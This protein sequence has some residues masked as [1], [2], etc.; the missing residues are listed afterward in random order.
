[1]LPSKLIMAAA[2]FFVG[3]STKVLTTDMDIQILDDELGTDLAARR[4]RQTAKGR[5]CLRCIT[6]VTIVVVHHLLD[7]HYLS[8][9]Q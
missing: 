9:Y 8:F 2:R 3:F 1:M 6:I 5:W 7:T 4:Y